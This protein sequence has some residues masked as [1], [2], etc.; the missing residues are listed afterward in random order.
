M[1]RNTC[2][3]IKHLYIHAPLLPSSPWTSKAGTAKLSLSTLANRDV[4]YIFQRRSRPQDAAQ[5]QTKLLIA[6]WK[7]SALK[8]ILFDCIRK[9]QEYSVASHTH[10]E[11]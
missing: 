4:P 1:C 9:T 2:A 3:L 11:W 10:T 7:S 8:S 6:V 5:Q